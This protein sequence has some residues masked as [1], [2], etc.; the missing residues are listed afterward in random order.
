M[1]MTVA[2]RPVVAADVPIF[3]EHQRDPESVAMADFPARSLEAHT[4]HWT[5]IMA[6]EHNRLRTILLDDQVAGN[7]VSWDGADGRMV[8]YWLGR[9]FWGRGLATQALQLF[10]QEELARPLFAHVVR[11]N[12]AS[13]R[14][15]EKCGF[16]LVGVAGVLQES[17]G[18]PLPELILRLD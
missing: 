17:T 12:V 16:V 18:E 13:R 9:E 2:I 15:L 14:V 7:I 3:F 8:G 1:K 5:K 10:I 6:G 4:A 11:H